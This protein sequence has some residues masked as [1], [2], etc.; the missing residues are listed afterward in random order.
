MAG[1]HHVVTN[2]IIQKPNTIT[3]SRNCQS[4]EQRLDQI[5]LLFCTSTNGDQ[6][7]CTLP[8][9]NTAISALCP[10]DVCQD[11]LHTKNK[12]VSNCNT[13]KNG[14]GFGLGRDREEGRGGKREGWR[15]ERYVWE[16]ERRSW[17]ERGKAGRTAEQESES[18]HKM[19]IIRGLS[20]TQWPHQGI[21]NDRLCRTHVRLNAG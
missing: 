4:W 19:A 2:P 20:A 21:F 10:G 1:C 14:C 6:T 15:E 17:R 7:V 18:C 13:K 9:Q 12:Q 16:R 8:R 11:S 5:H 3:V